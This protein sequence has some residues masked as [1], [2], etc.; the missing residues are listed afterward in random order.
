[1]ATFTVV[2]GNTTITFTYTAP[3]AT[4]VSVVGDAAHLLWIRGGGSEA[5]WDTMSNQDKLNIVNIYIRN[6]IVNYQININLMQQ[7]MLQEKRL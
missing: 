6:T 3:T 5:V 7:R 1:M 2:N 4:I